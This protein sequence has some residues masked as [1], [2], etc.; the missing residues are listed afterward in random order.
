MELQYADKGLIGLANLGNTC[1][2][3]TIMQCLSHTY[4][5][6][7][8]LNKK[9]YRKRLNPIPETVLLIE[10]DKLREMIW[11]EESDSNSF[12]V[13]TSFASNVRNVA[14]IKKRDLFTGFA[15]NDAPEFLYFLINSFHEAIKRQVTINIVGDIKTSTDDLA[16]KCFKMFQKLYSEEYSELLDVFYGIHISRITDTNGSTLSE[17]C[18]PYFSL[19]LQIP[20]DTRRPDLIGCFESFTKSEV[21][22]GDNKYELEDTPGQKVVAQKELKFWSFPTVLVIDLK[23]FSNDMKKNSVYV[24]F[25]TT[26]DLRKYVIGYNKDTY[27]YDLYAVCNHSGS[28]LGGHYTACVKNANGKWYHF[29]DTSV[30]PIRDV[31]RMQTNKAYCLF[32]RKKKK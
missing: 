4:E 29:N 12:I 13:P 23:R 16:S 15:Q 22:D 27:I 9:E 3:N 2:L 5:L 1:F 11:S 28:L 8:F 10:W 20:T 32:Y 30:T 31:T 7:D 6:N 19:S 18:E 17:I 24:S 26:L 25:P 21:L 14:K